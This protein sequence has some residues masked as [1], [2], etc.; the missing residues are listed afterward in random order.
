MRLETLISDHLNQKDIPFEFQDN[1]F[2]PSIKVDSEH[3]LELITIFKKDL[4]FFYLLDISACRNQE[5]Q[6]LS[7]I[8]HLLNIEA[9]RRLRVEVKCPSSKKIPSIAHLWPNACWHE[10]EL[11]DFWGVRANDNDFRLILPKN[12]NGHPLHDKKSIDSTQIPFEENAFPTNLSDDLR[13]TLA[14]GNEHSV[15]FL[16]N[17]YAENRFRLDGH[18]IVEAK[19]VLG[20]EHCGIEKLCQGKSYTDVLPLLEKVNPP[21]LLSTAN[22]GAPS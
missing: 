14:V 11:F 10:K 8:Y 20:F 22:C 18:K 19:L 5:G 12:L 15:E 3:F 21:R 13:Q 4:S 6:H 1:V 2:N 7:L 16:E 9:H 17:G